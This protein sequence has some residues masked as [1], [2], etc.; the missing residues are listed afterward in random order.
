MGSIFAMAADAAGMSEIEDDTA[1]ILVSVFGVTDLER[2]LT[3]EIA[4]LREE[5]RLLRQKL[6]LVIRQLF[7][8]KSEKLDPAQLEL[9]LSDLDDPDSGKADASTALDELVEAETSRRRSKRG[10]YERQPRVPENLPVV[11]T[12]L[13]PEVV[14]RDPGK[15]RR[16]GEEVTEL[17]DYEP[18]RFLRRR[19]VRPKY[20]PR[21]DREQPPIVAPLPPRLI[22]GGI[23][24]PG[25]L[26]HIV[27]SKYAD[28]LPLY[29]QEKIFQQR[30]QVKLPRQTMVRW[31][32]QVADW[33]KPVYREMA[34]EMFGCD[35]VQA[36]EVP[37]KYLAP[38]SGQ[39]QTGYLWTY[40][41]PTG[42][43]LFDWHASRG[44]ECLEAMVPARFVGTIQCDGYQAYRAFARKRGGRVRLAACWAH[45]RRKFYE[46][47]ESGEASQ[48]AGWLIRQ[49]QHLY[50]IERH[51][52]E[53]RA[54]PALREAVR[55]S[56]SRLILD[57][58]HKAL[59]R[60]KAS[61]LHLPKSL[62]GRAIEYALSL[63]EDLEV[64]LSDG[65][66]E[67]D[68]NL[69]ENAIRPT[70]VGRKNWL[71]MGSRDAGCR[72]AV[73]YSIIES[74]RTRGIDPSAYLKDV[75]TRLPD[76]TNWEIPALTPAAWAEAQRKQAALAA[77]S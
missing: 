12:I 37:V 67:L 10:D 36:D 58:F 45:V 35:Y 62:L 61:G 13:E 7:G 6:N 72:A 47:Y 19:T 3:E 69:C 23:A 68:N 70:A 28:H 14:T 71:F 32:E 51:L 77:A 64:F 44:Q 26:A 22:E 9:L 20:V 55:T 25:L 27:I 54:G 43:T 53:S 49:I 41:V 74:C 21:E 57:R 5:N 1:S 40:R 46:A 29:R 8:K 30:H 4:L 15:W 73:I 65:D 63:W 56:Q 34:L 50:R 11:E 16:I 42:N 17:L 48:R 76:A 31:I 2:K 52:R 39:A 59:Y 38:G 75:L 24:A 66:I 33:L 18:G 60:F